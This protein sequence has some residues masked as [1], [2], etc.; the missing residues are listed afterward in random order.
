MAAQTFEAIFKDLKNKVYHPVYFLHGDEPYFIDRI[1]D[2]ISESVLSDMEK[3]FNQSIVYGRDTDLLAILS[4]AKRYP[5]M[6]NYQVVLIREAQ[7]IKDLF[8]KKKD[9]ENAEAEK[10]S[11]DPFLNYLNNPQ[12]STLLVFCYKYKKVDKRTK[13]GKLLEKA[14]VF[15]ESKKLYDD[16]IAPWIHAYVKSKGY[17]IKDNAAELLAE[18]L[19]ADLSRVSNELDKL[20]INIGKDAEIDMQLIERNIG[21]SKDF[22]VF[23]LQ[24][25]MA[26]RDFL[27]VSRIINYFGANQKNNPLVLTIS[28]LNAWFTKIITF[29]V[30]RKKPGV[31][32]S[33]VMG[34]NS[35]FLRDY[36][37]AANT[38]P[39]AASKYAIS[40]LH[41]YDLRSKG[42]NNLSA[43]ENDLLK[44]LVYKIMHPSAVMTES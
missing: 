24:K 27:K 4:M 9:D 31:N 8:K 6:S 13:A 22:N 23:E 26:K 15:F 29:H 25:A 34:V 33:A 40:L 19:G 2:F 30:Y 14:S 7:D 20:M 16:K 42:V 11:A 43:N 39:L 1:A 12:K 28:T 37:Q 44:E 35:F 3:E 18:Y 21:I 32:M 17:K 38:F 41:E 5:M 36:E 10:D